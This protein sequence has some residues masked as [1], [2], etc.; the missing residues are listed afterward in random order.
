MIEVYDYII[1]WAWIYWLQAARYLW[2][3]WFKVCVL[4]KEE[5]AFTKASFVNQA[6]V[7]NWYH[8][9]RSFSTALKSK[10]YFD[11]FVNDFWFAINKNF[12][13]IYAIASHES[14]TSSLDFEIFCEK[15]GIPCK[16]IDKNKFFK[17]WS[18]DKAYECLEYAFDSIKIRDFM[19][20]ELSR[21]TNVDLNFYFKVDMVSIENDWVVIWSSNND[22]KFKS[23]NIINATYEWIN[24]IHE[25]F[26]IE[27]IKIKYELT[28][29]CLCDVSKN[30]RNYWLTVMDGRFL[31]IMPFGIW[32]KFSLSSV[33]YTP[34]EENHDDFNNFS[35]NKNLYFRPETNF[36]KMLEVANEYL[37]DDLIITYDKS[38][39]TTKV[40]L[41][42]T[43]NDD[44][45]P[46]LIRKYSLWNNNSLITLFSGKINTIY[47]IE[48]FFNNNWF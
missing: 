48:D 19:K 35:L 4:E 43:E 28:E 10:E 26:W 33:K 12:T 15:L 32:G 8:Y 34:H 7:H 30:L 5:D 36:Y 23:K 18:I 31:S 38:L 1:I 17:E 47:E 46:T 2:N 11:R 29:M 41:A 37:K 22:K 3:K 9:P 14:K 6:R 40:V 39:F 42:D 21:R 45:R 13:K 44:A 27:K 25:L 24:H 16:E 20:E